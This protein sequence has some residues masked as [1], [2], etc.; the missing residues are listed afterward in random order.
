MAGKSGEKTH[1]LQL[2]ATFVRLKRVGENLQQLLWERER[3][4]ER[5]ECQRGMQHKVLAAHKTLRNKRTKIE[6][7]S[8]LQAGEGEKAKGLL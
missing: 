1:A 5:R 2:C 3:G 4:K 6:R 8:K 7:T